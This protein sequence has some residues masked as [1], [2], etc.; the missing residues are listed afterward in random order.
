MAHQRWEI[1]PTHS[2][3]RFVV[4][5]M[6]FAK[7]R[8][9]LGRFGGTVLADPARPELASV[10]AV[11]EAASISTH[12]AQRDTQLRSADFLDVE[13]HPQI[14]FRSTRVIGGRGDAFT[15]VGDL[16]IRGVTREVTLEAARTGQGQD[17]WGSERAGFT[18]RAALDRK[19]FGL[20]WNQVLEA[21]G[22]LV[23]DRVDVELE[24]QAVRKTAG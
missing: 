11:I 21:G 13:H 8:G 5:H 3:I 22:V 14:T 4:R 23:A 16:T 10:T 17:P 2:S 12:E 20:R 1:D 9:E 6:V 24:V 7:V 15:V 18:A 19:E